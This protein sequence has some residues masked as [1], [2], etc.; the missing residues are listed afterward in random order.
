MIGLFVEGLV[1]MLYV[2]EVR[3][4]KW[5]PMDRRNKNG[6]GLIKAHPFHE[7][8][9]GNVYIRRDACTT[10]VLIQSL[11]ASVCSFNLFRF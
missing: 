1:P 2:V 11:T 3:L 8:E 10:L 5:D 6:V 4:A 7:D 9:C